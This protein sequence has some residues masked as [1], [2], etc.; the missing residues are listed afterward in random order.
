MPAQNV[1]GGRIS[2]RRTV[3][4]HSDC[5]RTLVGSRHP[6]ILAVCRVGEAAGSGTAVY[7]I[8]AL[9][10]GK[11]LR[12]FVGIWKSPR[13]CS[14]GFVPT[15]PPN[16][17]RRAGSGGSPRDASV[18]LASR[19][20]HA[21]RVTDRRLPAAPAREPRTTEGMLLRLRRGPRTAEDPRRARARA[22]A[23]RRPTFARS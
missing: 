4:L 1:V 18:A 22:A 21:W 20:G 19:S 13:V 3:H 7:C 16:R 15:W 8:A 23:D 10:F 2:R 14:R 17:G 9:L 6:D 11:P 12:D 5:R